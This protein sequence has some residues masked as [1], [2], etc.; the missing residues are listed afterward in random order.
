MK[1]HPEFG[2]IFPDWR[3]FESARACAQLF[4]VKRGKQFF[5]DMWQ[6]M[7]QTVDFM[8]ARLSNTTVVQCMQH[9]GVS[10]TQTIY[11]G[12][13][14]SDLNVLIMQCLNLC[15]SWSQYVVLV[16]HGCVPVT[17]PITSSLESF[18]HKLTVHACCWFIG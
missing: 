7:G 17:V 12:M 3:L 4:I 11:D 15:V 8:H 1:T 16:S 18:G 10:L 13:S 14:D 5:D 6:N 9:I 2:E